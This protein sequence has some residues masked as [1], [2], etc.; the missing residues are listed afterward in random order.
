MLFQVYNQSVIFL[1]W[2]NTP[3]LNNGTTPPQYTTVNMTM[4]MTMK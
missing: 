2:Y 3:L 4:T 1:I